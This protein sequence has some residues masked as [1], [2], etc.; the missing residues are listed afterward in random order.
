MAVKCRHGKFFSGAEQGAGKHLKAAS[1]SIYYNTA[2]SW[3]QQ[4]LGGQSALI[5][6]SSCCKLKQAQELCPQRSESKY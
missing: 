6:H 3:E 5:C 2:G 4:G 1:S